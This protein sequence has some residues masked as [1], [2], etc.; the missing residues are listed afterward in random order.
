MY[1]SEEWWLWSG[2]SYEV[3]EY[4]HLFCTGTAHELY[5]VRLKDGL[6]AAI[7]GPIESG[8]HNQPGPTCTPPEWPGSGNYNPKRRLGDCPFLEWPFILEIFVRREEEF[9]R[10]PKTD[11]FPIPEKGPALSTIEPEAKKPQ[12]W[13][14][15]AP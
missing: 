5:A 15:A 4:G 11:T 13:V 1:D 12:G 6:P 8:P 10:Y 14:P 7:S 9:R 3:N 2:P